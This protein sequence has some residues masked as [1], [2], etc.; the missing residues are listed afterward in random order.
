MLRFFRKNV[1]GIG[2]AVE[3]LG[4][5][6]T[7]TFIYHLEKNFWSEDKGIFSLPVWIITIPVIYYIATNALLVFKKSDSVF[8]FHHKTV[9]ASVL[10]FQF[11]CL[12]PVFLILS[13][14]YARV[15]FYWVASS[16]SIFLL[17]P[18]EQIER[19]IPS[20]FLKFSERINTCFSQILQPSRKTLVFLMIFIGISDYFFVVEW[21]YQTTMIYNI[22]Y[23]LSQPFILLKS[24]LSGII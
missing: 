7:D 15:I 16:F 10:I 12:S 1:Y 5:S 23:I 14:D 13:C 3:A 18:I 8:T 19:L 2:G 21:A 17:I 22:L 20:A 4:W 9:L 11:L 6:S 24:L